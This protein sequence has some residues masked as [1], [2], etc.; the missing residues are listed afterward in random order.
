LELLGDSKKMQG[1]GDAGRDRIRK[2]FVLPRLIRD[3]LKLI[4]EVSNS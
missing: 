1:F 4:K 3:E 2:E